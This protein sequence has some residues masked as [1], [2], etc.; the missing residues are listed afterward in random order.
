MIA[1]FLKMRRKHIETYGKTIDL[2]NKI[3][4]IISFFVCHDKF[5][6]KKY[7]LIYLKSI[8]SENWNTFTQ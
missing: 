8:E 5:T 3:Y 6:I 2:I 7:S 1:F 4:I